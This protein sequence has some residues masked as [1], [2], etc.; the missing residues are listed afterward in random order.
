[1]VIHEMI[2]HNY[3]HHFSQLLKTLFKNMFYTFIIFNVLIFFWHQLWNFEKVV[4]NRYDI[5]Q[6]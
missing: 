2:R 6:N 3:G 1:M 5:K 4:G